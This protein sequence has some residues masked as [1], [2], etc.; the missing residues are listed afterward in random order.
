VNAQQ[1]ARRD[2]ALIASHDIEEIERLEDE[3]AP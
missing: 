2:K 3:P 1:A